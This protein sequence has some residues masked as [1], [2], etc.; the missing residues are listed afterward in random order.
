MKC[1]LDNVDMLDKQGD[2][3]TYHQCPTCEGM[4]MRHRALRTLVQK[5][6]PDADLAMPRPEDAYEAF[7]SPEYDTNHITKCPLD[8]S[9]YYEHAFGSV[10]LD[11]C[12]TCDGVWMDKGEMEKIREELKNHEIPATLVDTVLHDIGAFF[13]YYF[14]SKKGND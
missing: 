1:P 4:W 13:A 3:F 2:G 8:G 12:P 7:H 5:Y 14:S 11:I 10:M 9:D 6:E